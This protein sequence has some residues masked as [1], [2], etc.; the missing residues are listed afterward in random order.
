MNQKYKDAKTQQLIQGKQ[1]VA[2]RRLG[3]IPIPPSCF[4]II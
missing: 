1:N 2:Y 4:S 3:E